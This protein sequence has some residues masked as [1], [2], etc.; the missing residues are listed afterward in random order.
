MSV[1]ARVE[2]TMSLLLVASAV[3]VLSLTSRLRTLVSG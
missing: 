3:K 2:W 1:R